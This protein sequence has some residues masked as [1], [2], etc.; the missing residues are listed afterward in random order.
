MKTLLGTVVS[1]KTP[2]TAQVDV[3]RQWQHPVYLKSVTRTKRYACHVS[4][5]VVAEGDEVVIEPTR[6]MSKTKHFRVVKKVEKV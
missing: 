6:P 1:V 2:Q 5:I 3:I 4:D